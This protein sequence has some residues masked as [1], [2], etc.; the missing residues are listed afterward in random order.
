MTF[1]PNARLDT[2]QV[3]D[4]RGRGGAMSSIPGG[5]LTVGGGGIGIIILLVVAVLT[6]NNPFEGGSTGLPSGYSDLQGQT[7]DTAAPA[8]GTI[9]ENCRTGADANARDDCRIVGYVNSVQKYWQD[10]FA[11]A[12]VS[13]S[14]SRTTFFTGATQTACGP[15][16]AE[17][18]PFYCPADK[19]V[20]IDLAFF[21]ELRRRFGATAGPFAQAYV[22]AH[23]YGHHIQD[24]QGTLAA[25]GN[26][27]DTGP[28]SDAVRVELQAD[29]Y[30]GVW[31]ANAVAT[32]FLVP[33]TDE[34]IAD[35][36]NAA[37]AVGDDRIQRST[38]GRVNPE[39]WTHGSAE[40][41]QRWFKQG[42][43]SGNPNACDTFRGTV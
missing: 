10:T 37:A 22:I 39:A 32:G 33:L 23:E 9:A 28:Q 21:N 13:Y 11:R 26:S 12:G 16:S 6:G 36:L 5:G 14:P 2:S 42:Y 4:R 34:Q 24:I 25:A 30:A 38:Q 27:R 8:G 41:R 31:A 43:Q 3:D 7:V 17:V 29:C 20:Y 15:A 35:A 40:Q 18:G 1:D 19:R